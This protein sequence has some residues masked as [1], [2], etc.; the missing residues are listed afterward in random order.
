MI[1]KLT[2]QNFR[3]ELASSAPLLIDC[4]TSRSEA[5]RYNAPIVDEISKLY[6]GKLRVAK[7]NADENPYAIGTLG[8]RVAPSVHL[9][10]KGEKVKEFQGVVEKKDIVDEIIKVCQ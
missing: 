1:I 5:C 10:A 7:L 3:D 8:I 4:W 9:Y 2:D 6:E